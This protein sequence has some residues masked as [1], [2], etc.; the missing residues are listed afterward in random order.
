MERPFLMLGQAEMRKYDG[1]WLISSFTLDDE[2]F[3]SIR[4]AY[5]GPD[6]VLITSY[7]KSGR[8]IVWFWVMELCMCYKLKFVS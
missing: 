8:P 3:T 4:D 2:H 5:Y 1:Q 6:D 7:P